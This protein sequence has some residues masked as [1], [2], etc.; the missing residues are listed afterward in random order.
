MNIY[1]MADKSGMEAVQMHTFHMLVNNN[2]AEYCRFVNGKV[3]FHDDLS[4]IDKYIH[5]GNTEYLEDSILGYIIC[6]QGKPSVPATCIEAVL[7]KYNQY[8]A[9]TRVLGINYTSDPDIDYSFIFKIWNAKCN[10]VPKHFLDENAVTT[11]EEL[12]EELKMPVAFLRKII[13]HYTTI[14]TF[15]PIELKDGELV[16]HVPVTMEDWVYGSIIAIEL[17]AIIAGLV[18]NASWLVAIGSSAI[19][20][21]AFVLGLRYMEGSK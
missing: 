16:N 6:R 10:F 18:V 2:Y 4:F 3:S 15:E 19:M 1:D 21:I 5:D 11:V 12:A 13:S 14:S 7:R 20:G 17:A 8:K 9:C